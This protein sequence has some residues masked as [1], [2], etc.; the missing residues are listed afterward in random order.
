MSGPLLVVAAFAIVTTL[1]AWARWLARRRWAAAGHLLMAAIAAWLV[2]AAW[3]V[4][5]HLSDYEDAVQGEAVAELYFERTGARRYR[6]TLTRLPSG[7][8]QVFDLAGEEWRLDL[9][10]LE[11]SPGAAKLGLRPMYRLERLLARPTGTEA[12]SGDAA[13]LPLEFALDPR[14][15]RDPWS[16]PRPGP[17]W[18]AVARAAT[19]E[20]P[21]QPMV[22]G[23]RFELRLAE[24]GLEVRPSTGGGAVAA[25][26]R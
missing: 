13:V 14:R 21:W 7:R 16:Q 5:R 3:P 19:L 8:M 10:R 22:E 2:A 12:G 6:A 18:G 23:R 17:V 24:D 20:S 26:E 1:L 4:S 11:W 25:R 15:G 9:R